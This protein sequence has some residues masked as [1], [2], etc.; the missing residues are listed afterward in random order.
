MREMTENHLD[1]LDEKIRN[2]RLGDT[3]TIIRGRASVN[4][5]SEAFGRFMRMGRGKDI[6]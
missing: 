2:R 4:R 3:M 5:K 1:E 6:G